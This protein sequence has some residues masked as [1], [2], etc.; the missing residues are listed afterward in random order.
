MRQSP[1][2]RVD[3]PEHML[4]H[5]WVL[6]RHRHPTKAHLGSLSSDILQKLS[7][8][9][10]CWHVSGCT[11]KVINPGNPK[12]WSLFESEFETLPT[13]RALKP[14]LYSAGPELPSTVLFTPLGETSLHRGSQVCLSASVT[15]SLHVEVQ[16]QN[17][18]VEDHPKA[19]PHSSRL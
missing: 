12:Q 8:M 5:V 19:K 7:C 18:T 1:G 13:L 3:L 17:P 6:S 10:F 9:F 16:L 4:T 15:P 11:A 2:A 14:A